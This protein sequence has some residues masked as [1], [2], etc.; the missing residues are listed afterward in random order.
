VLLV[1]KMFGIMSSMD[2][3]NTRLWTSGFLGFMAFTIN[4][5]WQLFFFAFFGF[6]A[7]FRYLKDGLKYVG[8]LGVLGVIVGILGV[9]KVFPV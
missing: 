4:N 7:Y 3:N 2:K 6:F 8:L 1:G 5:P 9:L